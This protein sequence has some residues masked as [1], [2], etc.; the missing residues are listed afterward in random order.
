MFHKHLKFVL[1]I[2]LLFVSASTVLADE[3][4][5]VVHHFGGDVLFC[6]QEDGCKLLNM[7]GGE[8][9]HQPQSVIDA[10]MI[11]ACETGETQFIDA[12]IGTYG[13]NTLLISCFGDAIED[14]FINMTGYDEWGKWNI[15]RFGPD[16]Q[17]VNAPANDV[18]SSGGG[19][20]SATCSYAV[21][22]LSEDGIHTDGYDIYHT[23]N[24]FDLDSEATFLYW[25]EDN[26]GLP[27]CTPL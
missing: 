12:G 1:I 8:L 24:D 23:V 11:V 10:A 20:L 16:Y 17:P 7:T 2:V 22:L 18:E 27:K 6:T 3:R 13:P 5:N 19:G 25:S 4:I 9:W 26:E 14:A 15:I 21:F